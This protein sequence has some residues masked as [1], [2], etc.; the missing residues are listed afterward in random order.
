MH[1]NRHCML[2]TLPVEAAS[3][4]VP[5][6]PS[7][8]PPPPL[9]RFASVPV[10]LLCVSLGPVVELAAVNDP[11]SEPC[12]AFAVLDGTTEVS[13]DDAVE[14][15]AVE[16]VEVAVMVAVSTTVDVVLLENRED[17]A[18]VLSTVVLSTGP[19]ITTESV[20]PC[21]PPQSL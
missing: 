4:T 17:V 9:P 8:L 1:D 14:G 6:V 3:S 13:V 18:D 21:V 11:T 5:P 2:L 15:T 12:P 19:A 7:L 10:G 16:V 20:A